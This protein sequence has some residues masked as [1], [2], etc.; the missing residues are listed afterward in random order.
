LLKYSRKNF[1]L[2]VFDTPNVILRAIE[3][4][5]FLNRMPM[6]VKEVGHLVLLIIL[7]SLYES[8]EL[9]DFWN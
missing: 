8:F 5:I 6:E 4:D 1:S 9:T 3:K 2:L 7:Q